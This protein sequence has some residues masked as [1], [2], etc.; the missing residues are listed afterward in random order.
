[1]QTDEKGKTLTT[2]EIGLLREIAR[3][4]RANGV[5]FFQWRPGVGFGVFSEWKKYVNRDESVNVSYEPDRSGG[6]EKRPRLLV[7]RNYYR[8][9]LQVLPVSTITEA[10]DVLVALGYLPARFSSA[11]RAG[12]EARADATDADGSLDLLTWPELAPA[13]ES[14]W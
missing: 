1:M 9:E 14:A 6:E 2:E 4:R 8:D 3:W 10:V 12:W 13:V 5:S 7:A 11:Y